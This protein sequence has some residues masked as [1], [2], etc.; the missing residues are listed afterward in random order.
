M[1]MK[2]LLLGFVFSFSLQLLAQETI[3]T[4]TAYKQ[5]VNF[6]FSSEWQYLSTDLYLLNSDK[7]AYLINQIAMTSSG[8]KKK[9]RGNDYIQSLFIQATIKD[10]KFF[11][12][13]MVYPI[14]S[15]Q[16]QKDEKYTT[17]IA[18]N[19]GIIRLIDNLPLNASKDYI[20]A[21]ISGDIITNNN[22]NQFLQ[23]LFFLYFQLFNE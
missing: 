23:T 2:R 4:Y 14:Y 11:G 22:K 15:F 7:F 9:H 10:I 18:D 8:K 13:D 5:K 19:A 1:K 16:I 3:K 21:E 20:D 12:G 17:Q 6:E